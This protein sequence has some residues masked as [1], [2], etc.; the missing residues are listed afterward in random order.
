MS[1]HKIY[2]SLRSPFARR[3]RLLFEELG[4]AYETE[5]VDV[6]Q[7]TP[8]LLEANPLGRVPVLELPDRQRIVDSVEIRGYLEGQ[9]PTHPLFLRGGAS[10]ARVRTLCALAVGIMDHVIQAYL[11]TLRAPGLRDPALRQD[12]IDAVQRALAAFERELAGPY[13]LGDAL[14][15]VD[16][17]LGAALGYCDLRL[18]SGLVDRYPAL[19]AYFERLSQRQSFQKTAPPA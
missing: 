13:L 11:E 19:R 5:T 9:F 14:R 3:I 8:G 12:A 4:V 16:L 6:F 15:A 1:P 17:D 2:V 18:G 7:P 10:E